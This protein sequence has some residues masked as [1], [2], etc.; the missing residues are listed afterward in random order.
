MNDVTPETIAQWMMSRLEETGRLYQSDAVQ[1][2]AEK[3]GDEYTYTNDNG[4]PAIDKR[5]LKAFRIITDDTVIWE[6]WD[7]CWRKREQGDA[8]GRKQE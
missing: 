3:F 2:I 1:E 5:I 7:F 8:P 6:R 4:N